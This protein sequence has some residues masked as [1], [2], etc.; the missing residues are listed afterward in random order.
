MEQEYEALSLRPHSLEADLNF[1]EGVVA[2][3]E[4]ERARVL[5]HYFR[6]CR[7]CSLNEIGDD[8][9]LACLVQHRHVLEQTLQTKVSGCAGYMFSM[10]LVSL[11]RL[12][13][14]RRA[15]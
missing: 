13:Q 5:L 11:S 2:R 3:M 6:N 7:G 10:I 14:H 4:Q 12:A 8:E 1:V 9:R 15:L